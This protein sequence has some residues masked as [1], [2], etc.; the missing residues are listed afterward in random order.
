MKWKVVLP[1]AAVAAAGAF[2]LANPDARGKIG[3]YTQSITGTPA[4]AA[5]LPSDP[6]DSPPVASD[7]PWDGLITIEE[8]QRKTL[9]LV[10]AAVKAQDE[11]SHLRLG[12]STDNDPFTLTIVRTQ[13]NSRVEKVQVRLG[14]A[15]KKGQPLVELF[16]NTLAESK[17][18]YENK[19]TQWLHDKEL[20]DK[21]R[22]LTKSGAVS[23][24]ELLEAENDE[25]KSQ[26]QM[27]LAKDELL[28]YG[29]TEKEIENARNE[30]G[31]QKA[32]MTIRSPADGTIIKQE[33]APG[34]F[35]DAT[36]SLMVISPMDHLWVR[37]NV[38][39]IDANKVAIG[40][41]LE[42]VFPYTDTHLPGKVEYIDKAI[43]PDTRA[44]KF[45]TSIPNKDGEIKSGQFVRVFLDI[46]PLPGR[47]VIPRTAMVSV[48]R[49][50]YAFVRK[51]GESATYERRSIRPWQ[52][53]D[54]E[55][56]V[57]APSVSYPGLEPGE[58]V[59]TIGSL[60]L[61]QIFEDKAM[62]ETGAPL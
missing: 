17:S 27:K 44:A 23:K 47:T 41:R 38:N 36:S 46:P 25:R 1:L 49:D 28:V 12:G 57:A 20:V 43:D 19:Y 16:S 2:L 22:E 35:Y 3:Q 55:V 42:V 26:V 10:T 53:G 39:E 32:K 52:E 24:R 29:L 54:N 37:G 8:V 21:K 18:D 50:N 51:P 6:I 9:G 58:E 59:V 30:V 60:I 40:Q 61:E 15:V 48:D 62:S 5:P 31:A 33:V 45:R 11:P 13:F 56:I 14:D 7:K 34:N 4:Q